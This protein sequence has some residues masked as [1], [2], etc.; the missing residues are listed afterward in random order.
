ME[1]IRQYEVTN[2]FLNT[3]RWYV[4]FRMPF[5]G[6]KVMPFANYVWLLGNPQFEEIPPGYCVHHLDGDE[7]N[8]DITNLA[9]MKKPHHAAY[10]LK[11]KVEDSPKKI[12]LRDPVGLGKDLT[13]PRVSKIPRLKTPLWRLRWQETDLSGKRVARQITKIKGKSFRTEQQ[14]DKAKKLLMKIHPSFG[15][16]KEKIYNI[17]NQINEDLDP[18]EMEDAYNMIKNIFLQ[19]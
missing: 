11:R 3:G 6:K 7:M 15:Q 18:E 19:I 17:M 16:N 9:L 2:K 12:K 14:A 5:N 13:I 10:H 8:D 4:S 1:D